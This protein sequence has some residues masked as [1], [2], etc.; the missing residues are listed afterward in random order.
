MDVASAHVQ[1]LRSLAATIDPG[2][3]E[4]DRREVAAALFRIAVPLLGAHRP[5][6]AQA[7][8]DTALRLFPAHPELSFYRALALEQRGR[9]REAAQAFEQLQ[10]SLRPVG[11]TGLREPA[12]TAGAPAFLAADRAQLLLDARVQAALAHGRAGSTAE[13]SRRMKALFAE[14]PTDDGVALGLLEVLERAGRTAEAV[15]LLDEAA[16]K[17]SGSP[18]VLFARASALDRAGRIPEAL[19]AMR[20][21]MALAP[22]HAG[23]L[24]YIGYTMAERGEDLREAEGLLRRAVQLRPDDGAIADSLGFCLFK[25]GKLDEALAELRRANQLTP[26]D[27]VVLGHLGD[28]LAAAGRREE[29]LQAF[30]RALT[31]LLPAARGARERH[32]RVDDEQEPRSAEPGDEKVRAE[33][34]GKLR[35]LTAP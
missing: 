18:A 22:A 13:A 27:P 32:A 12:S 3:P 7:A 25:Q 15:T 33:I 2:A 1:K 30:R 23:A 4:D 21:L 14:Q 19:S 29:A 17:H 16:R 31:R 34:E 11:G 5:V 9:H 6:D 10:R 8:L 24:N 28:A 26:G 20:K 35:S